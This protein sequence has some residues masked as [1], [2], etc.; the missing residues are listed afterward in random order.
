MK[1]NIVALITDFGLKDAY[2]ALVKAVLYSRN[3]EMN[4]V[5]LTHE[6]PPQNIRAAA[7]VLSHSYAHFPKKTVFM[8][9]VDP[10]VGTKRQLL[11]IKTAD[12][13]FVGPDNGLFTSVL[14]KELVREI[15]VIQNSK[16]FWTK[17]PP[18]TFHGRDI[19]A[20]ISGILSTSK[21]ASIF[22]QLGP[23]TRS[24]QKLSEIEIQKSSG[25][26]TGEIISFD[27]FGNAMTN[28]SKEC[29]APHLWKKSTIYLESKKVGPLSDTYH[30]AKRKVVAVL[31][32]SGNL[33]IAEPSGSIQKAWDLKMGQKVRVFYG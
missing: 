14:K 5:D 8:A 31:N 7:E 24:Y 12:Y 3:P 33:E 2:V 11:A 6:I 28:L 4:V 10:G 19:M 20:P 27:Y 21:A 18:N 1:R 29:L 9:V 16:F 15:R 32:S 25:K 13:Y 23:V 30:S 26:I 17:S 22:K